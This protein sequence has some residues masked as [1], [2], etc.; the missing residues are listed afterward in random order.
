MQN[1]KLKTVLACRGQVGLSIKPGWEGERKGK[2]QENGGK[3]VKWET[4]AQGAAGNKRWLH[5]EVDANSGSSRQWQWQWQ[6]KE[7]EREGRSALPSEAHYS[8]L[9]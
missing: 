6:W 5:L 9:H 1:E 7:G 4:E 3:R 2:G 8:S